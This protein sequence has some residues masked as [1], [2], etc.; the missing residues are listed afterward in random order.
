MSQDDDDKSLS[1]RDIEMANL[2]EI[3]A[4]GNNTESDNQLG[5]VGFGSDTGFRGTRFSS[6]FTI[7][8]WGICIIFRNVDSAIEYTT[9]KCAMAEDSLFVNNSSIVD[10]CR[11]HTAIYRC[12]VVAIAILLMQ[13]LA[14]LLISS[15]DTYDRFWFVLKYPAFFLLSFA[16]LYSEG[17]GALWD[18]ATFA[19]IARF[20]AFV[21]I[22]FQSAVFLDWAYQFN[23]SFVSRAAAATGGSAV[24]SSMQRTFN[25]VTAGGAGGGV[26]KKTFHLACLLGFALVNYSTFIVALVLLFENFASATCPDNVAILTISSL[27][28]AAAVVV[29]MF[30]SSH[31]SVTTTSVLGLYVAYL[32]YT[33]VALNPSV[34][35]NGSIAANTSG[36]S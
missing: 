5:E 31:G 26:Q 29:Q 20:A 3:A 7:L 9:V 2:R 30:L 28:M 1:A 21:F 11:R 18:D 16:L 32:S 34:Q 14:C 8:F 36:E 15:V 17:V 13:F 12:A 19:W 25:G 22:I 35:C 24:A 27:C 10:E 33:A 4:V 6:L 23:Q